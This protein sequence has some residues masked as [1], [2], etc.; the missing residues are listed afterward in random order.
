MKRISPKIRMLSYVLIICVLLN[1][2]YVWIRENKNQK[3]RILA[4]GEAAK[5]Y[6]D[7]LQA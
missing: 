5:L 3:V 1:L 4:A 6:S 2:L 7:L